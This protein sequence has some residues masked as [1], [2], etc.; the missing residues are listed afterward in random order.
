MTSASA[1]LGKSRRVSGSAAHVEFERRCEEPMSELG[2]DAKG[3][4]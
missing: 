3:S 4:R 2:Q 1:S